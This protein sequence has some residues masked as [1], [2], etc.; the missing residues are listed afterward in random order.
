[1]VRSLLTT[2][3]HAYEK[4]ADT[5]RKLNKRY[6]KSYFLEREKEPFP[7]DF[8]NNMK[9]T[10]NNALKKARRAKFDRAHEKQWGA[11][12]NELL[13]QVEIRQEPEDER[14]VLNV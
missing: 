4:D 13:I 2:S 1:M 6:E 8:I 11:D 7:K 10:I 5:P 9:K 3:Q 12:F 14:F